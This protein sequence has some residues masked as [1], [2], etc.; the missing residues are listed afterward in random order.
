METDERDELLRTLVR[1]AAHQETI[2]LDLRASLHAQQGIND[3]LALAI[4][5]IDGAIE[6]LD[7]TQARIEALLGRMLRNGE[8]GQEA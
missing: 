3:R 8:N 2:N 6:R 7:V 5:R 1:I 4:E